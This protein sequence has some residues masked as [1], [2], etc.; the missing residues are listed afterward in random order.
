MLAVAICCADP[1][2]GE[3]L[4]QILRKD[5]GIAI[6]ASDDFCFLP[7]QMFQMSIQKGRSLDS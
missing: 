3:R 1:A 2:L 7:F 6:D 4:E 5:H